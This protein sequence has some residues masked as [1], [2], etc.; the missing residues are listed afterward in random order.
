M[1][2][3]TE[4]QQRFLELIINYYKVNK[5]FPTINDLKTIS[6]YKSY[7]SLYKYIDSLE[8]KDYIKYDKKR[9]QITFVNYNIKSDNTFL[10]PF[11]ENDNYLTLLNSNTYQ[12]LMVHNNKL[13]SFGIKKD[14]ILVITRD[15]SHLNNKF[16]G[17]YN[18]F[19]YEIYKHIKK[20]EF[21]YL[22]NDKE[23]LIFENTNIIS[24]K[25]ISLIR[26]M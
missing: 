3:I 8:K 12:S 15:L 6:N 26:K 13:N 4:Y 7:N 22:I 25:V 18:E 19:G 21:H 11:K 23:E 17:I 16:V 2:R 1:K 10:I 14:D 24:F 20:G 9:K 5:I